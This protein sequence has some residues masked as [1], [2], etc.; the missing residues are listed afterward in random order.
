MMRL[1]KAKAYRA[2]RG[3]SW[4]V[5]NPGHESLDASGPQ[6]RVAMLYPPSKAA[7]AAW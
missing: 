2:F 4:L 1:S 5:G 7:V 3:V 6:S